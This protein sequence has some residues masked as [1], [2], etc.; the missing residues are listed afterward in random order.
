MTG[1]DRILLAIAALNGFMAVVFGAVA[2]HAA[3]DAATENLLKTGALWQVVHALATMVAIGLLPRPKLVS[4][5]FLGG[6]ML[7][8][9]SIYALAF[10]APDP[11]A[12]VTPVGGFL[13]LAGW[14]WLG[15]S[16]LRGGGDA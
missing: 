2:A 13:M 14:V 8:A 9:L 15:V 16:A 4:G 10:G 5:L 6:A 7:F 11:V 3:P 1:T 12:Y